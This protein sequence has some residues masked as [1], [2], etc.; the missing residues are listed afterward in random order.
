MD[1]WICVDAFAC[2]RDEEAKRDSE[3]VVWLRIDES[4]DAESVSK[5]GHSIFME[6][7]RCR[8]DLAS[9]C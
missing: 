1:E 8:R 9:K 6:I 2:E 5:V 4:A 7:D 3:E